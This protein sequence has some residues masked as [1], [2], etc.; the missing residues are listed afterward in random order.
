MCYVI[1]VRADTS[2][3]VAALLDSIV[4]S[5]GPTHDIKFT[6]SKPIKYVLRNRWVCRA[7]VRRWLPL[8]S[9]FQYSTVQY[10]YCTLL[11]KI[12]EILRSSSKAQLAKQI[13]KANG[14]LPPDHRTRV[15]LHGVS[16][17]TEASL[18]LPQFLQRESFTAGSVFN[19]GVANDAMH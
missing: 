12:Y 14:K 4:Q 2:I 16:L 7:R 3:Y 11:T 10:Q 5:T 6:I 18:Q 8:S 15:V 1:F 17:L 9:P 19:F 13:S